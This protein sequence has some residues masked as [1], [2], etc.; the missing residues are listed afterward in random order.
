M[1]SKPLTK[2]LPIAITVVF[3]VPLTLKPWWNKGPETRQL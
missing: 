3:T 2:R 1:T